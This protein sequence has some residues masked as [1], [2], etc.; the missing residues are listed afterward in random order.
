MP[1]SENTFK[2]C[3]IRKIDFLTGGHIIGG[4]TINKYFVECTDNG[5]DYYKIPI[6]SEKPLTQKQQIQVCQNFVKRNGKRYTVVGI[7]QEDEQ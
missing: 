3:I 6:F 4:D 5:R 1:F 2:R 7:Y